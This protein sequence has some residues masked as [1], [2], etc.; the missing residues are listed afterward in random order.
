MPIRV[1]KTGPRGEAVTVASDRNS[2]DVSALFLWDSETLKSG[3]DADCSNHQV[4]A[5]TRDSD[6]YHH[7]QFMP[8]LKP[9]SQV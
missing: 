7:A 8:L 1:P 2:V 3:F 4:Q 9:V 5:H 6:K